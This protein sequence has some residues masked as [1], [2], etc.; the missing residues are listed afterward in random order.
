MLHC[1]PKSPNDF[2]TYFN[3]SK[4]IKIE[5]SLPF[6]MLNFEVLIHIKTFSYLAISSSV[7]KQA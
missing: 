4:T 1:K 7:T 3:I 2:N 6:Q 5:E